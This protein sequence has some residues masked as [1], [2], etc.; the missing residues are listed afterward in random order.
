M[1]DR[2]DAVGSGL[3]LF[4]GS[5]MNMIGEYQ[6]EDQKIKDY[7]SERFNLANKNL[8][9]PLKEVMVDSFTYGFGVAEELWGVNDLQVDIN[10]TRIEPAPPF[11]MRFVAAGEE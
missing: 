3:K 11:Y 7:I 10:F 5:V 2:D 6:N 4:S 9:A 8:R 1:K